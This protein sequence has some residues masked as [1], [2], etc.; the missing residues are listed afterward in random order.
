MYIAYF[1]YLATGACWKAY[2]SE[3]ATRYAREGWVR[4]SAT[5]FRKRVG[6]Y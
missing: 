1:V 3:Q 4:I 2:T 6:H 5:E